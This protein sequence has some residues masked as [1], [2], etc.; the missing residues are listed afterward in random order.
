MPDPERL[1]EALSQVYKPPFQLV[2][3]EIGLVFTT[4]ISPS[5]R[6]SDDDPEG[7][8]E[9]VERWEID[10]FLGMYEDEQRQITIFSRAIDFVSAQMDVKRRQLEYVVRLHEWSHAAFHLAVTQEQS[11]VLAR[12]MLEKDG[13]TIDAHLMALS[14]AYNSAEAYVHEQL[15][16]VLTHLVLDRLFHEAKL[17]EA[18]KACEALQDL[19][20]SL[21]R[22]QP[23]RYQLEKNLLCLDREVL[24]KRLG[25]II[26]L[27]RTGKVRGDQETWD[28]IISW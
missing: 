6:V 1:L 10:N 7:W 18:K 17:D 22:R 15:A 2:A 11:Y 19:F 14:Q 4:G 20:Q 16:Q 3:R 23:R 24:G 26:P 5:E 27:L 13:E 12:S 28:K 9:R 21:M 8:E 25:L